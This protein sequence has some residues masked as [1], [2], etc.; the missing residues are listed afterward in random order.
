MKQRNETYAVVLDA[1]G[2]R[3]VIPES[4][5]EKLQ[6]EAADKGDTP[7]EPAMIQTFVLYEAETPEDFA[8]LIPDSEEQVNLFNRGYVLKQ[9]TIVRQH[10]AS[11]DFEAVEGG[12]DLKDEAATKRIRR[13]A[14]AE[15]KLERLVGKMDPTVVQAILAKFAAQAAS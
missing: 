8:G 5:L 7:P 10:L 11:D 12:Y 1:D 15:E 9:Q 14:T 3:S 4:R 6:K 13:A 2:G